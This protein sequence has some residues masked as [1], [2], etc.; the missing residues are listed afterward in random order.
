M[1]VSSMK[2][3]RVLFVCVLLI[4]GIQIGP[5]SLVGSAGGVH[6]SRA[7]DVDFDNAREIDVGDSVN[8]ALDEDGDKEDCYK[9]KLSEGNLINMNL[10]VPLP[11]DFDMSVYDSLE[12]KIAGSAGTG[13]Y[14]DIIVPIH[15]TDFYY[16]SIFV[17]EGSGNYGFTI[18]LAG[19][20]TSDGD[21]H[22]EDATPIS[23]N[24]SESSDLDEDGYDT[25][26]WWNIS[27]EAGDIITL[28][29]IVPNSGDFNLALLTAD[30]D[31]IA[32]GDEHGL[33]RDVEVETA[34]LESAD[35]YIVVFVEEGSGQYTITV[36]R[37]GGF[38]PDENN[39]LGNATQ[40]QLGDTIN[41]MLDEITDRNDWF[42]VNLT[43]G[44]IIRIH[45]AGPPGAD[46]DMAVYDESVDLIDSGEETG[47][48]EEITFPVFQTNEYYIRV[49]SYDGSGAYTLSVTK[50]G[51]FTPDDDDN[52]ENATEMSANDTVSSGLNANEYDFEDWW[53]LVLQAG[54]IIEINLSLESEN[55]FELTLYDYNQDIVAREYEYRTGDYM[56]IEAGILLTGDHYIRCRTS[57]DS[58][59]YTMRVE[60]TGRF[61]PD[62]DNDVDNATEISLNST[63]SGDVWRGVDTGDIYRMN[64]EAGSMILAELDVPETGDFDLMIGYEYGDMIDTIAYSD[65]NGMGRDEFTVF[66]TISS[67]TYYV[68]VFA[69]DGKGPYT[70]K[71]GL[72][73]P[74]NN[75]NREDAGELQMTGGCATVEGLLIEHRDRYD[76]YKF[77]MEEGDELVITLDYEVPNGFGLHL[78]N[79]EDGELDESDSGTGHEELEFMAPGD[80]WC[81]ILVRCYYTS[82]IYRLT[83]NY[84]RVNRM[85]E[86]HSRQP[87]DCWPRYN[88]GDTVTF[89]F[90]TEDPDGTV[91]VIR[92]FVD[93]E[94]VEGESDTE[95]EFRTDY[96]SEGTYF[97][98]ARVTD[99]ENEEMSVSLNWTLTIENVDR[100]PVLSN[101]TASNVTTDEET[102]IPFHI[103]A[104]DPDGDAV[105]Y[106]W[107][108]DG[109]RV[110]Y[111]DD[112]DFVYTP[113]YD[114]SGAAHEIMVV[115]RAGE[116]EIEHSWSVTV[117]NMNRPPVID[118]KSVVPTH[119]SQFRHDAD[120]EFNASAIDPDGDN[121]SYEW[122]IVETGKSFTEQGFEHKLGGGSYR[123]RVKVSDGNGGEDVHEFTIHVTES[124]E[125]SPGFGIDALVIGVMVICGW[126][127]GRR[128]KK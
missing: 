40:I 52:W 71:T 37:T 117:S 116:V 84:T 128:R 11:S 94:E 63:L 118:V 56:E 69:K 88:E 75:D 25:T 126:F 72:Y 70:L 112:P 102:P 82:G 50:T 85:P 96:D 42:K 18:S 121:I 95:F 90:E 28:S 104:E 99:G 83:V 76:W 58:I 108:V 127:A 109:R 120:I 105:T 3:I 81:Y 22:P 124:S 67:G 91:P 59:D 49:Y 13:A 43:E 123:I 14:E 80:G 45:L 51:S 48:E 98:L 79:D 111:A 34:I 92:W 73:I 36:S 77:R 15:I 101:E 78:Y 30:L 6:S 65:Q 110:Q 107:Y 31:D 23:L 106:K 47:L 44:D 89:S 55:Y 35:Y 103:D 26:D 39:D 24:S 62:G 16:I 86:V 2:Q 10:T 87:D 41:D 115:V 68:G 19:T 38:D 53:T 17:Y 54:D 97:I 20:F 1:T 61:T 29:L 32:I 119:D 4:M 114:S 64:L 5:Q 21:N 113:D 7:R 33:G 46:F 122:T 93:G 9:V 125:G 60:R 66:S 57:H 27:L 12:E 74:D 8:G 100:E